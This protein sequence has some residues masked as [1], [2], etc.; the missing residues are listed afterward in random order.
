MKMVFTN[1]KHQNF[2]YLSTQPHVMAVMFMH[3]KE[4]TLSKGGKLR[5][6]QSNQV[7][8]TS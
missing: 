4:R 6:K 8:R 1:Q 3:N 5:D 7:S 2:L